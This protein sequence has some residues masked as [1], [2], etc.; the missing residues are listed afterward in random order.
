M[1]ATRPLRTEIEI[2]F[3]HKVLMLSSHTLSPITVYNKLTCIATRLT[4]HMSTPCRASIS[5]HKAR[6]INSVKFIFYRGPKIICARL[7]TRRTKKGAGGV[8]KK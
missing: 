1:M 4:P 7:P 6:N 5:Y 3:K 8:I 2:K